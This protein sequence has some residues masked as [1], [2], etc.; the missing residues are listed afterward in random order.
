MTDTLDEAREAELNRLIERRA[1]GNAEANGT[2]Q[3]WAASEARYYQRKEDQRRW[4]WIRFSERMAAVHAELA[5]EHRSRAERLLEDGPTGGH[6]SQG[7][8]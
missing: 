3:L 7:E 4:E 8:G 2:A 1:E 5:L 6:P